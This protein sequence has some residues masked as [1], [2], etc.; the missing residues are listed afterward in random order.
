[1]R[2]FKMALIQEHLQLSSCILHLCVSIGNKVKSRGQERVTD[3]LQEDKDFIFFIYLLYFSYL[4]LHALKKKI[5]CI[6]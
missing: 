6:S 3:N 2:H 1:M 5:V 4:L